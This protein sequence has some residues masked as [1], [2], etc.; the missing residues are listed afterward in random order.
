MNRRFK[1][2]GSEVRTLPLHRLVVRCLPISRPSAG[3]LSD[4][5]T[6]D[7]AC[8]L[9]VVALLLEVEGPEGRR[10]HSRQ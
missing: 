10:A 7:L 5:L 6:C 4:G 2:A 3:V 9:R 8:E 1:S